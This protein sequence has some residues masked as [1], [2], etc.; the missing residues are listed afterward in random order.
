MLPDGGC[1]M[2]SGNLNQNASYFPH[3]KAVGSY[4][5]LEESG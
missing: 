4:S 1:E 2:E 3:V 5:A